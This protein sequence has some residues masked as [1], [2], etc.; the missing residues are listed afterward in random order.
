[1]YPTVAHP[2]E[3][4]DVA[5]A[6]PYFEPLCFMKIQKKTMEE[7]DARIERCK[8]NIKEWQEKINQLEEKRDT[9]FLNLT[10]FLPSE[11]EE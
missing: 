2:N 8:E 4:T 6:A 3:Y 5:W 9:A 1:M 10:A 7:F 11:T